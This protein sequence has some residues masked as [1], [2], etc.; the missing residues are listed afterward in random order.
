MP[1]EQIPASLQAQVG[2]YRSLLA[3][4]QVLVL[5]DNALDADQVRPLLPGSSG[6]LVVV[7][8]RNQLSGLVAGHGAHALTLGLMPLAEARQL[9]ARRL[10]AG[11]AAAEPHAV[12]EIVARCA[13]LPLALAIVAARA[14]AHPQFPLEV[15]A[16]ELREARGRLDA[17]TGADS[18]TDVRAAFSWSYHRLG[19]DGA[20]I[21][22]LFGL[23]P[24]PDI[25]TFTAASLG[26]TSVRQMRLL[27]AELTQAHLVT[28]HTPG[29]YVTH[30]LLRAYAAELMLRSLHPMG[31]GTGSPPDAGSAR[32]STGISNRG[33]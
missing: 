18:V 25:A 32:S 8:S 29:R 14:A 13:G 15:L 7:T 9:L 26:G 27:L 6:C 23:H 24:G 30:E 2:L 5:L 17:F 3:G 19:E 31:A 28:E 16:S 33:A 20:R 12:D 1:P 22:R 21:F 11:R 4:R 10:G